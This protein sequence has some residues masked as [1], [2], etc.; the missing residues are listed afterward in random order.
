M[1]NF[2]TILVA[3]FLAFFVF[4]VLIFS[5][6]IK[7]GGGSSGQNNPTGKIVVW[8]TFDNSDIH[9]VFDNLRDQNRD[10]IINYVVKKEDTY[11]ADLIEAFAKG[12]GPDLFF[13]SNDM[14]INNQSFIYKIP[15]ASY[16]EKTFKDAFIDGTNVFLD[17]DGVL[18]FP[19]VVDPM[20]LYY[21]KDIISN[22]GLASVPSYWDELFGLNQSLTKKSDSGSIQSSMIALGR[23]ENIN[24]AKDILATLLLQNGNNIV[25]KSGDAYRSVFNDQDKSSANSPGES[26]LKFFLEFSNPTK[27]AYSWNRAL[28][29]SLDMFTG[30]KLAFYLGRASELFKIESINPNLSFDV[31]PIL[32]TR[33]SGTKRT[34]AKMY[35]ISVNKK[36]S[37]LS[38]AFSVAGLITTDDT[39]KEFAKTLSLP[40]ALRSLLSSRPEDPYLFTFF[41]SAIIS[42]TWIDPDNVS[43]D[44][45]FEELINNVISSKLSLQEAIGKAHNQIEFIIKK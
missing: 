41:N 25:A 4:A 40:P 8:G 1:N 26:V 18:G 36:S 33:D 24:H 20:V 37:N 9:K 44:K 3:I 45:I 31:A 7:I 30:G 19:I 38:T 27:E 5:G 12:N 34:Y 21:N 10:L 23:Y 2:Q 42:R 17:K 39:A 16:P 43:S 11:Q 6:L 15:F 32:Q 29:N 28:P 35:A 13:I 14:I 22:A